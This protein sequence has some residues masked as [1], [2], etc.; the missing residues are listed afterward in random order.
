MTTAITAE[1][2]TTRL[3]GVVSSGPP[4]PPTRLRMTDMANSAATE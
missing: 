2:A 4:S 3:T 1:A